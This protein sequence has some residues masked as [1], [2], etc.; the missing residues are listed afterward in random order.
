MEEGLRV[1][2]APSRASAAKSR[3]D[4]SVQIVPAAGSAAPKHQASWCE[5]TTTSSSGRAVPPGLLGAL[6]AV[7]PDLSGD[8]AGDLAG[9]IAEAR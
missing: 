6:A 7:D 9:G 1:G 3:A 8:L 2:R 4:S 5:P